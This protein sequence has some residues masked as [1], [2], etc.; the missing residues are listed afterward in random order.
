MPRA[1][2]LELTGG[3]LPLYPG[4]YAHGLFFSLLET[5]NPQLASRL[6][7]ARRK[8][9]T[10]APL[11]ARGG[12]MPLR[13]TFLDDELF[14][15]FLQ[16]LLQRAPE[17]LVL[18]DTP[19]RLVR[20]L[21]SPEVHPLAGTTS[22]KELA[23]ATPR[24]RVVLQFLTP[25]V[26]VTSKPG[27]RTRYTP[28]PDPRLIVLSLLEKWQAHS[29]FPYNPKEEAALKTIF[30][31]DLE[32]EGFHRLRYHR[33]QAG[34]AFFPGFMGEVR[35]RLWAEAMEVRQALARLSALA[36]Y[37]GVGAKTT[38]GMGVA[39]LSR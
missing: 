18:G 5:L 29:P 16:A 17:G 28:L 15:G 32:L 24:D 38:F 33:I 6:H 11:E 30:D 35:L 2:V 10:L 9:F 25:T 1:V 39:L 27:D 7:G 20:V 36:P 22:W 34:K 26:F 23:A 8:P 4:R 19:F 3:E 12:T 14:E 31:L 13:L 21:A 37:S